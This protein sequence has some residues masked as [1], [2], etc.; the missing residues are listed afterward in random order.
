MNDCKSVMEWFSNA[1]VFS[2]KTNNYLRLGIS[3]IVWKL[4]IIAA[5]PHLN[6]S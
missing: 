4:K 1:V 5:K 6:Y 3:K 2:D